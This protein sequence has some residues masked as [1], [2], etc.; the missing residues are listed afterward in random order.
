MLLGVDRTGLGVLGDRPLSYLGTDPRSAALFRGGL[1]AASALLVAFAWFV[2]GNR[3]PGRGFLAAFLVGQAGQAIAAVVPIDGAGAAHEV[4][5]TAGIV[6]GLSLPVLMWRFAA[7][8]RPG[9]RRSW[10]YGLLWL[11]VAACVVGVTLSRAMWAALAEAVPATGFHLW[12]VVVTAW[13]PSVPPA[14]SPASAP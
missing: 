8:Q 14:P 2:C 7:G 1:L 11:E 4:H 9:H 12:I 13:A 10:A 3:R 5:T 6:L